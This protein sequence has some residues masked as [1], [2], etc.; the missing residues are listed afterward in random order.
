VPSCESG[1]VLQIREAAHPD[2]EAGF[3]EVRVNEL[4]AEALSSVYACRIRCPTLAALFM[5]RLAS[6]K[7]L[8]PSSTA[9]SRASP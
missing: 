1:T 7:M 5:C 8:P 6:T 9:A 3:T 2:P 4:E